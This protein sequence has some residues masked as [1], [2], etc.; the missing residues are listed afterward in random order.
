MNWI[1][2]L[3]LL[4]VIIFLII[5]YRKKKKLATLKSELIDSWG[6]SKPDEYFSFKDIR[7]YFDNNR[8]KNNAYHIISE[9]CNQDLD[10]D[11]IFKFID[12]TSSKIGQQFLYNK[13]RTVTSLQNLQK[14]HSLVQVFEKEEN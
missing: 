1:L 10:L 8:H 12:R 5:N 2:G 13:L 14:Y 3:L 4:L 6:K 11:E 9:K 7:L